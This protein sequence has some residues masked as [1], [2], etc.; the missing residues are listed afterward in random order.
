MRL[1]SKE[2]SKRI[3]K[4]DRKEQRGEFRAIEDW[5]LKGEALSEAP[6]R[7]QGAVLE[8]TSFKDLRTVDALRCVLGTGFHSSLRMYPVVK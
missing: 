3:S 7:M 2:S 5:L 1:I 6:Q 4:K 8:V